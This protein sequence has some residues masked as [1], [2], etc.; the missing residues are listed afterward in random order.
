[1]IEVGDWVRV[2]LGGWAGC[3]GFVKRVNEEKMMSQVEFI[4]DDETCWFY[5][6]KLV[7]FNPRRGTM[8]TKQYT[9]KPF[10]V[11]AV[12][13]TLQNIEEVA[14][15]CKGT[16]EQVPTKMMG[17]TTDLPVIRLKGQGENRGKDFVAALGCW[18]VELKGSFR[19]YKPAQ[20]EASFEE[21]T[22]W[23]TEVVPGPEQL[24]VSSPENLRVQ[25]LDVTPE[26]KAEWA[27]DE[28]VVELG[29]NSSEVLS[30]PQTYMKLV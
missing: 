29:H 30:N 4:D 24:T 13:V 18:V 9:R 15:W 17:T 16:I 7:K 11:A 20:F 26:T 19:S 27:E 21:L 23:E 25:D 3:T 2:T 22:P 14:E 6:Y 28:T 12:Q 5:N 10:P 8:E 1:M